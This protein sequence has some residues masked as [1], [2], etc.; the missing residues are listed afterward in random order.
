MA[1]IVH[2]RDFVYGLALGAGASLA[3]PSRS[4]GQDEPKKDDPKPKDEAPKPKSEADARMEL[5]VARFGKLLDDDARKAVREEVETIVKR[6]ERLRK[7]ELTNGDGP[8][9]V[10]IPYRTPLG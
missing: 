8:F 3:I 2:R 10:F 4:V 6:A 5:I 1:D 7:F 9:A